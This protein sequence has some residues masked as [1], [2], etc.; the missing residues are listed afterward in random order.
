MLSFGRIDLGMCN[1]SM[2]KA[3]SKVQR[4][5]SPNLTSVAHIQ[6]SNKESLQ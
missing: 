2:S 6:E 4:T 5:K 1:K 3:C